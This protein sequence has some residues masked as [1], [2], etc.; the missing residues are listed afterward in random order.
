LLKGE[1]WNVGGVKQD[2]AIAK[3]EEFAFDFEE[4]VAVEICDGEVSIG[5]SHELP[6]Y[7]EIHRIWS[8]VARVYDGHRVLRRRVA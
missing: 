4:D 8:T 3:A 7:V 2:T 1:N 6:Y 5:K